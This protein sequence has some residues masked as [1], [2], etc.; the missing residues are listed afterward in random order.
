MGV[1]KKKTA[2]KD[3]MGIF[4]KT[5]EGIENYSSNVIWD[6]GKITN[7][8]LKVIINFNKELFLFFVKKK[9]IGFSS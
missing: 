8:L 6:K 5:S 7:S 3:F 2:I 9:N 1:K 4:F